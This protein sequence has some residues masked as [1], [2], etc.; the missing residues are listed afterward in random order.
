[1]HLC[2]PAL[3][4]PQ[5]TCS[6]R[7]CLPQPRL[8]QPR[9]LRLQ[10]LAAHEATNAPVLVRAVAGAAVKGP[11]PGTPLPSAIAASLPPSRTVSTS[12]A[13]AQHQ[14]VTVSCTQHPARIAHTVRRTLTAHW[15][16]VVF[17]QLAQCAMQLALQQP[18]ACTLA[19]ANHLQ[20]HQHPCT[21]PHP[22]IEIHTTAHACPTRPCRAPRGGPPG[23]RP[24]ATRPMH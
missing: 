11:A 4:V 6:G 2:K 10:F 24:A 16:I 3:G 20:L 12:P 18:H 5:P 14:P 8:P 9:G 22:N 21:H 19:T 13:D 23:P 1:M 17:K 7:S 15:R